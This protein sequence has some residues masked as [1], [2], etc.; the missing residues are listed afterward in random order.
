MLKG[1]REEG[2]KG[3]EKERQRDLDV[4]M[5]I[6]WMLAVADLSIGTYLLYR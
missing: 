4:C 5:H 6:W 1:G 2:R 3:S